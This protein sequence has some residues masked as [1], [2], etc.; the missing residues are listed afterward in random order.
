MFRII[1]VLFYLGGINLLHAQMPLESKM[2][3]QLDAQLR[4]SSSRPQF[5]KRTLSVWEKGSMQTSQQQFVAADSAEILYTRLSETF[6]PW[7]RQTLLN[8]ELT[9]WFD[10]RFSGDSII[11]T[12]KPEYEDKTRVAEQIIVLN[13]QTGVVEL[14]RVKTNRENWLYSEQ[15][16]WV[17]KFDSRGIYRYHQLNI[18]TS[19]PLSGTFVRMI[20]SGGLAPRGGTA[21]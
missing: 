5:F 6:K 2:R 4:V 7:M 16:D 19:V 3:M 11:G 9:D 17:V 18:L 10:I 15:V 20:E 12:R 21:K 8:P 13:K 14:V 1:V